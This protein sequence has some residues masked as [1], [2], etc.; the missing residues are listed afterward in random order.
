MASSFHTNLCCFKSAEIN[1]N[2]IHFFCQ[3]Q[4]WDIHGV[5][6]VHSV[7]ALKKNPVLVHSP[8]SE[9]AETKKKCLRPSKT[10]LL[11]LISNKGRTPA[12]QRCCLI[13]AQPWTLTLTLWRSTEAGM[14]FC[15]NV[16]LISSELMN[17]LL[18]ILSWVILLLLRQ[19]GSKRKIN[20]IKCSLL[21]IFLMSTTVQ[22]KKQF[23]HCVALHSPSSIVSVSLWLAPHYRQHFP[24][25]KHKHS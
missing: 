9:N 2:P 5:L 18:N 23:K 7:C 6:A 4:Q 22:S 13:N 19:Q 24:L 11:H 10:A 17:H 21:D 3:I 14:C 15:L 25:S 12:N 1:S 16:N 8:G 20:K